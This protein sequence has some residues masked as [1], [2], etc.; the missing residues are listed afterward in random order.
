MSSSIGA[1]GNVGSRNKNRFAMDPCV[2]RARSDSLR[3]ESASC[4]IERARVDTWLSN[5]G[6]TCGSRRRGFD[7]QIG[8]HLAGVLI[9]IEVI[10]RENSSFDCT[11]N[12]WHTSVDE[13]LVDCVA[14]QLSEPTELPAASVL[15]RITLLRR[16]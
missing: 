7:G 6:Y 4:T 5:R 12:L 8:D 9:D 13:S 10:D 16:E 15:D 11:L 2:K 1:V 3:P 14:E